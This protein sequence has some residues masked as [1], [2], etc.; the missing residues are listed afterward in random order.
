MTL[1]QPAVK[2][3]VREYTSYNNP[4]AP[5]SMINQLSHDITFQTE[6]DTA[7]IMVSSCRSCDGADQISCDADEHITQYAG[8][9]TTAL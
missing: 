1:A 9:T 4:I 5:V 6:W 3:G 2:I 8:L 7:H